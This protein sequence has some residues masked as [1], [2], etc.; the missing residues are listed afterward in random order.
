MITGD[1]SGI[2]RVRFSR[3]ARANVGGEPQ[4]MVGS[5]G[6]YRPLLIGPRIPFPSIAVHSIPRF[7][8][9][10][11]ARRRIA[12]LIDALSQHRA[13]VEPLRG[14]PR[15]GRTSLEGQRES[16]HLAVATRPLPGS[17]LG[18]VAG[19]QRP[20]EVPRERRVGVRDDRHVVPRHPVHF[21]S[22]I[23]PL[24]LGG[25][26]RRRRDLGGIV[27]GAHVIFDGD[28]GSWT[29]GLLELR[30]IFRIQTVFPIAPARRRQ[31]GVAF[32][33]GDGVENVARLCPYRPQ[34][35]GGFVGYEAPEEQPASAGQRFV[36]IS[37][38]V[39]LASLLFCLHDD[40]L[41][42]EHF[43][44]YRIPVIFFSH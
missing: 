29:E 5:R 27:R 14:F 3:V 40:L 28:L 42:V 2:R 6:G 41:V 21:P 10:G 43:L 33:V 38:A 1:G 7:A 44:L 24:P 23:V 20:Q 22:Q 34:H 4:R 37:E 8:L 39:P 31:V 32:D 13:G 17:K 25:V 19:L 30:Q 9:G 11:R 12:D 16:R 15:T 18:Q 36:G 35:F 26:P